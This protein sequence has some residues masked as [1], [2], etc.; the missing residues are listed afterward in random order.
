MTPTIMIDGCGSDDMQKVINERLEINKDCSILE[1]YMNDY[2]DC[3]KLSYG[4]LASRVSIVYRVHIIQ[5]KPNIIKSYTGKCSKNSF[6]SIVKDAMTNFTNSI[7]TNKVYDNWDAS[8]AYADNLK[9]QH[10]IQEWEGETIDSFNNITD[11]I[12]LAINN[13]IF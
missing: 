12:C 7:N 1:C 3:L 9:K 11:E 10:I 4:Y 2:T 5:T 8:L 6:K 13:D